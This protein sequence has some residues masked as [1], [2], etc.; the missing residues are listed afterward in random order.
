MRDLEAIIREKADI[1]F[2]RC[3]LLFM[4]Q[5]QDHEPEPILFTYSHMNTTKM[6]RKY[7][8]QNVPG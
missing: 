1:E 2:Q 8:M 4:L 3:C 6:F 7:E 5:P